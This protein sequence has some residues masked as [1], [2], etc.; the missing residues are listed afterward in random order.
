M[1]DAV[2]ACLGEYPCLGYAEKLTGLGGVDESSQSDGR[3]AHRLASVEPRQACQPPQHASVV[4]DACP[5]ARRPP[6][7]EMPVVLIGV[8]DA[9][10]ERHLTASE[11]SSDH[12]MH[13]EAGS[14]D[15]TSRGGAPFGS[16][17][18][19]AESGRAVCAAPALAA[20]RAAIGTVMGAR[21]TVARPGDASCWGAIEVTH[22]SHSQ[23]MSSERQ[24]FTC[25]PW[26]PCTTARSPRA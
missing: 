25:P 14:R 2:S 24:T 19:A 22:R 17:R 15:A 4:P 23:R 10:D 7:E 12:A 9:A 11:P 20:S 5:I 18:D 6:V 26:T 8:P 21:R 13:P 1:R 3:C 16:G